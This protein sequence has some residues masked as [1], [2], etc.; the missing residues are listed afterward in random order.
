[1]L[2]RLEAKR[3]L[4]RLTDAADSRYTEIRLTLEGHGYAELA[5]EALQHLDDELVVYLSASEQAAA[6]A[7]FEA[8]GALPRP[9]G[10]HDY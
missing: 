10:D 4:S 5:R 9:G 3:M 8:A 1:V 7:L 6:G 2:D